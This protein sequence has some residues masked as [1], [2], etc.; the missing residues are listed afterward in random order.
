MNRVF[1]VNTN[2]DKTI[3][4]RI[5][6]DEMLCFIIDPAVV[7]DLTHHH[8]VITNKEVAE[9][10]IENFRHFYN[11]TDSEIEEYTETLKTILED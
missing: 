3:S 9:T 10:I 7:C 6:S 4:I 2:D 5:G 1:D 11:L 8:N